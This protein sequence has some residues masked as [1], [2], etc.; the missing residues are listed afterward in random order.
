[1][2]KTVKRLLLATAA[3]ACVFA[4]TADA[5]VDTRLCFLKGTLPVSAT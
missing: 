3:V 1:M 2:N 4:G 5:A